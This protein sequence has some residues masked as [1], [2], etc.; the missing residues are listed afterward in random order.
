MSWKLWLKRVGV[1][2]CLHMQQ[3]LA[4][5]TLYYSGKQGGESTCHSLHWPNLALLNHNFP[6]VL[7]LFLVEKIFH[8]QHNV[9]NDL[10]Q[11]IASCFPGFQVVGATMLPLR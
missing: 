4:F 11:I 7:V 3:G 6:Q 2:L 10:R 9:G 8:F 5:E 1:K